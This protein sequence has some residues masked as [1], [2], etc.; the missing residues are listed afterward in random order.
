MLAKES[1][2]IIQSLYDYVSLR[3]EEFILKHDFNSLFINKILS[4]NIKFEEF[5]A[6]VVQRLMDTFPSYSNESSKNKVFISFEGVDATG[7]G[8]LSTLMTT[9]L[10][11]VF[12]NYKST[13]I[14]I[15]NYNLESGKIISGC[16]ATKMSEED[17]YK[18][19]FEFANHFA[20]NRKE[21]Q[22]RYNL[23]SG[24]NMPEII[25]FDRWINSSM[26]FS[27]AK[28]LLHYGITSLDQLDSNEEAIEE[29]KNISEYI[30]DLELSYFNNDT[31][32]Q[33]FIITSDIDIIQQRISERKKESSLIDKDIIED[34]QHEKNLKLLTLTD[35]IFTTYLNNNKT[36]KK[37]NIIYNNSDIEMA[38]INCI[39][40]LL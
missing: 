36:T 17:L 12:L 7:K 23:Y 32:N 28:T 8:T 11:E 22:Y 31:I 15:P 37:S 16:L 27:I 33:E 21:V 39:D 35:E 13:R 24:T 29:V 25:V 40:E 14:N 5:N 6:W 9:L 1:T 2:N 10:S 20:V 26:A 4:S 19:R 18:R 3:K 30:L 34:D 38:L